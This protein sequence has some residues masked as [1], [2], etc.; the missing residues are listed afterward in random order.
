MKSRSL[1][2]FSLPV[3]VEPKVGSMDPASGRILRGHGHFAH[4]SNLPG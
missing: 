2:S 4:F 1:P 3:H